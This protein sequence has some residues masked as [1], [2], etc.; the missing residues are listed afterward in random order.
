M[1]IMHIRFPKSMFLPFP[2]ISFP[3]FLC[4]FGTCKQEIFAHRMCLGRCLCFPIILVMDWSQKYLL[5]WRG[6]PCI[7]TRCALLLQENYN[8]NN[9]TSLSLCFPCMCAWY[10]PQ[11]PSSPPPLFPIAV[12][13]SQGLSRECTTSKGP[14]VKKPLSYMFPDRI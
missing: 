7:W 6:I 14:R 12:T 5:V 11:S 3:L 1:H 13:V 8:N 2:L 10:W 4:H 9:S